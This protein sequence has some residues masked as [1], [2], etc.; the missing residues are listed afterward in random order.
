MLDIDFDKKKTTMHDIFLLVQM[1]ELHN[2]Y[3]SISRR[4]VWLYSI[5]RMFIRRC[6]NQSNMQ[7]NFRSSGATI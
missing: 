6:V 3:M 7:M 5:L 4:V 2:I 1:A